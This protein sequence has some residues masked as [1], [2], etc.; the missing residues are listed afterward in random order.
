M[1][2]VKRKIA[3]MAVSAAAVV[4][5]GSSF[6]QAAEPAGSAEEIAR[7]QLMRTK[8]L[9]YC[10]NQVSDRLS[11]VMDPENPAY[12]AGVRQSVVNHSQYGGDEHHT[13]MTWSAVVN[14]QSVP[15][16]G[17]RIT[18]SYVE[19]ARSIQA[20]AQVQEP[21]KEGTGEVIFAQFHAFRDFAK[22]G[23]GSMDTYVGDLAYASSE[24][25]QWARQAATGMRSAYVGCLNDVRER[26]AAMKLAIN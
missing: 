10:F 25:A 8:P 5:M 24:N 3:A 4:G 12:A 19:D 2:D 7:L 15:N 6:A 17:R 13:S 1:S 26:T 9:L 23:I 22:G 20:I 16:A 18:M 21:P 11:S 14:G